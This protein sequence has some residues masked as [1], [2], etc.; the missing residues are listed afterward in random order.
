MLNNLTANIPR[1]TVMSSAKRIDISPNMAI[2]NSSKKPKA[3]VMAARK[4]VG[5]SNYAAQGL[6]IHSAGSA[7]LKFGALA[8]DFTRCT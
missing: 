6:C 8:S 1:G 7:A 4:G 5:N 2:K 3:M